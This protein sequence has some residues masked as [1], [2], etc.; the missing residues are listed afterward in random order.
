MVQTQER[1]NLRVKLPGTLLLIGGKR[2]EA[3][4][5]K[6][7]ETLNPATEEAIARVAEADA[8][9]IDLAVQAA[10]KAFEASSWPRLSAR[11][12]GRLLWR[13]AD[14]LDSRK[15]NLARLETLDSGKPI[16]DSRAGDIPG[17]ADCFR[18]YAGWCDKICGET[19][20]VEGS[21]F[22]YTRREPVGVVGAI[23]PWNFPIVLAAGKIAPALACGC[24]VV[25]KPA[26]QT[27]LSALALGEIL[28][29][30]GVPDG[31]VNV[32]PG[33]G[34][35]AG[36]SLVRHPEVDM[37]AFTG[38]YLTGQEI[39]RNAAGNLKRLA[40]ELGG[41][42]PH[43][44]FADADLEAAVENAMTGVFFNAGQVCCAGTR[45]FLE[46]KICG[47]FTEKLIE[48][49]RKLRQGDPFDPKTEIGP[50]VSAEQRD[51]VM[52]YIELGKEEGARLLLGG[53]RLKRQGFFVQ[54]T[55]FGGAHNRMRIAREEIFGPLVCEIPFRSVDDV[56][57]EANDTFYGLAAAVWTRDIEKAHK[58]ASSLKAGTVWV[59]C[60][61]AFDHA[62]PFGGYKMSGFGR[63]GG[64]HSIDLYT[65]V[66]SVWVA[67]GSNDESTHG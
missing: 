27:P 30:A 26:E 1:K 10:R 25:L 9:D 5:G 39:M 57:R 15:E 54:P 35:T 61:G 67:L 8:P 42:S 22:N 21:F 11:E 37:I 6:T 2:L 4:S 29:E 48:K 14:I 23:T 28:Q 60:Y 33:F 32:V 38:E 40:F 56:I 49:S 7:F 17:A 12:R 18:Y 62:S 58:V 47:A 50:Q 63:E 52:R 41:K 3:R 65:E 19:I 59:N 46:K 64:K 45:L 16:S 66:K 13:I 31:V 51:K 34:P 24:T 44:V 36:A 43:I 55:V 20:P 53:E